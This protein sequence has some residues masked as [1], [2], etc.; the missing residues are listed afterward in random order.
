MFL[1]GDVVTPTL[2]GHTWFEKPALLYWLMMASYKLFGVTEFSARLGPAICGVLTSLAVVWIVRRARIIANES[3]SS[4]ELLAGLITASSTGL[5]AF[6]RGASFHI[7]LTA[8]LTVTLG[9]FLLAEIESEQRSRSAYLAG[10]YAGIGLSL[11]AKG[12]VG[13]VIPVGVVA[14]YYLL[15]RKWPRR[16][17]IVSAFWGSPISVL[18]AAIWYLPV[19]HRH[20]W[21]FVNEFFVQH[22]FARYVSDKYHHSEP[23][24]YYLLI[25]W[26]LVLP[27][28]AYVAEGMI[29][30]AKSRFKSTSIAPKLE[31]F[32]MAWVILPIAFFSL[33]GSKLPGYILPVVPAASILATKALLLMAEQRS[34]RWPSY[35]TGGLLLTLAIGSTFL[36]KQPGGVP[37]GSVLALALAF[38]VAGVGVVVLGRRHLE[39]ITLTGAAW[40]VAILVTLLL[41]APRLVDRQS[42]K[43]PLEEARN[44]GYGAA[45]IVEMHTI[46]RTTEFYAADRLIRAPDG[47]VLKLEGIPPLIGLLGERNTPLLVVVPVSLSFQLT[48]SPVL[49]SQ[50]IA[51]NGSFALIAVSIKR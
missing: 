11:L 14:L 43:R 19:I 7:V 13:V 21:Q 41:I 49:T 42:M 15:Q 6:S 16:G 31:L 38:T 10:F 22:H 4:T 1:R 40:A 18:V 24:Y 20:G 26:L 45:P 17:V 50:E 44:L 36:I 47:E 28:S 39:C 29:R 12:L 30:F 51:D 23:V 3:D 5:V 27:W 37:V 48:T 9:C 25:F 8:T 34:F 46:E 33:S 32:S 35:L 2:G